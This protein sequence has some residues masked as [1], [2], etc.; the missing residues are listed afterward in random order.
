MATTQEVIS[1]LAFN[2]G[3]NIEKHRGSTKPLDLSPWSHKALTVRGFR[4]NK[5]IRRSEPASA[6]YREN[7]RFKS[8]DTSLC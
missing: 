7:W 1:N 6:I 3:S 4:K 8:P 2:S 5:E